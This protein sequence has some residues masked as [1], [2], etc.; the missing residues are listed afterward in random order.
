MS[1]DWKTFLEEVKQDIKRQTAELLE[2]RHE[3]EKDEACSED[4]CP[5]S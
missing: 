3:R 1:D 2:R 4:A 5:I